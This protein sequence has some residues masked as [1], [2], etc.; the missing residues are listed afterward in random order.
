MLTGPKLLH[1]LS[2]IE[3]TRIDQQLTRMV[4]FFDLVGNSV[5]K[6]LYTSGRANRFNP[7][8]VYALYL[9]DQRGTCLDEIH[10]ENPRFELE[11]PA[12]V[13]FR[14]NVSLH[15]C[16]DLLDPEITKCLKISTDELFAN[17]RRARKPTATQK[18]GLTIENEGL[19]SSIRYPSNAARKRGKQG[20][21]VVIFPSCLLAAELVS[22]RSPDGKHSE[23]WP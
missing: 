19:F 15:R 12:D 2:E 14:V 6:F 8:G 7:R 22:I 20:W 5:G 9:A 11:R 4:D 1:A 3:P 18:L 17:W 21:N 10:E 23:Q 16:L 13:T